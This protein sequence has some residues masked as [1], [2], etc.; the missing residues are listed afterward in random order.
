MA[1]EPAFMIIT[2]AKAADMDRILFAMGRGSGTFANGVPVAAVGNPSVISHW[3]A[4]DMSATAELA[5]E[6][7]GM[8]SGQNAPGI[9]PNQW[10]AGGIITIGDATAAMSQFQVVTYAG[11]AMDSG[12]MEAWRG[13]VL[14]GLGLT[15]W[16]E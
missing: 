1:Y 7:R 8:A 15:W 16:S 11:P 12:E 2:D 5:A 6:F 4:Q 10:G 9:S 13:A 3:V 14:S